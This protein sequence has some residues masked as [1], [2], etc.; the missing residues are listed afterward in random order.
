MI[1]HIWAAACKDGVSSDNSAKG[2]AWLRYVLITTT[3]TIVSLKTAFNNC[4]KLL[5]ENNLLRPAIGF[6]LSNLNF[7][8]SVVKSQPVWRI[9][10]ATPPI[11]TKIPMGMKQVSIKKRLV[12]KRLCNV[13]SVKDLFKLSAEKLIFINSK[14]RRIKLL[15]KALIT[16]KPIKIVSTVLSSGLLATCPLDR[17]SVV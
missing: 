3:I 16:I 5:G 13:K 15:P 4:T 8:V 9:L 7:K 12:K 10:I 17:K 14:R 2:R 6:N 11:K 1:R